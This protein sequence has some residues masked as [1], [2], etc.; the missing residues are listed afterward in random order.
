MV[1]ETLIEKASYYATS[2]TALTPDSSSRL[3]DL[4]NELQI[5]FESL[6]RESV[7]DSILVRKYACYSHYYRWTEKYGEVFRCVIEIREIEPSND[8]CLYCGWIYRNA[9]RVA[10]FLGLI[11]ESIEYSYKSIA[12]IEK[13]RNRAELGKSY[14]LIG[15]SL[16]P[17]NMYDDSFEFYKK[18]YKIA[19]EINSNSSKIISLN[20]M[21]YNR[22]LVGEDDLAE[23][24][25]LKGNEILKLEQKRVDLNVQINNNL[26]LVALH[27]KNYSKAH[28]Y[29][30]RAKYYNSINNVA[31][32]TISI[33]QVESSIYLEEKKP[34]EAI[35]ALK[36]ALEKTLEKKMERYALKIEKTLAEILSSEDRFS[37]ANNHLKNCLILQEKFTNDMAQ[38]QLQIIKYE[39]EVRE[40][41]TILERRLQQTIST[42]SKIGE[43]RDVY[44]A[45]HQRRVRNLACAIAVEIGLTESEIMN[46]SYGALIHDIGKIYI[47]SDILNKPGKISN[48]EYQILQTHSELG[49]NIVKEV[50]FPDVIPTMIYQHHERIDGSGYPKGLSGD[51]II[52][53]SRILAVADVV[54]AMSSHRP[55]RPALGIDAALEEIENFKGMKFDAKVVDICIQLIREKGFI[56]KE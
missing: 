51:Q 26:A 40:S 31:S 18:A 17:L 54:E 43:L 53:E 55:Y 10:N 52:I 21:G 56:F 3:D 33:L 20:N 41:R 29:I 44:T 11:N 50:E 23:K 37:E 2:L 42:I 6:P 36:L 34:Q 13:S 32:D 47:A 8:D 24:L 35:D 28:E 48:L 5:W 19:V 1:Y 27:K 9:S 22:S 7:N 12:M 38:A 4:F 30:T 49:Y 16:S 25:L 15:V 45:G 39:K 46:L 14:N